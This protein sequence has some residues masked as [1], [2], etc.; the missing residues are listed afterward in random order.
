MSTRTIILAAVL[1]VV[2][3]LIYNS[4]YVVDERQQALVL[5]FGEPVGTEQTPGLKFK[6]PIIQ[7]VEYF[8]SRTL[9]VDPNPQE[10]T[11]SD[12]RRLVVDAFIRYRIVDPLAF[13]QAVRTEI[14]AAARLES[15]LN[16]SVRGVLG[17]VT[18]VEILSDERVGIMNQ[19][20]TDVIRQVQNLGV[21]IV[22]VRIGRADVP[23]DTIQSVYDR[24]R[25]ERERQ[26]ADSRAQGEELA[27]LIRS[28]A[29][30]ERTVLLAEAER[31]AET[32][33]GEG[34]R[35]AIQITGSAFSQDS[36]FY[37]FYRSLQAYRTSLADSSTTLVLPPEGEFFEFFSSVGSTGDLA[38]IPL[39][40]PSAE[41]GD[42][43]P[44]GTSGE[45]VLTN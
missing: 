19:I 34:D 15:A 35:Q 37:A 25:S 42:T 12:Q 16:S 11:F 9:N 20:R 23:D 18:P 26:A 24:M 39:P 22:D 1:V 28:R 7:Q 33:R 29:D 43:P 31:E 27:Q 36:E 45:E 5:Q 14:A 3:G 10:I 30:R 17:D 6:L 21:E 41:E 13:Y 40:A 38:P 44:S 2:G 4:L 32:L 8:E